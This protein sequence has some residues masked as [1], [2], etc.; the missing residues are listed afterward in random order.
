MSSNLDISKKNLQSFLQ[1]LHTNSLNY[2]C[3]VT[4]IS[5]ISFSITSNTFLI[6]N[7]AS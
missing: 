1:T 7:Q 4:S 5:L 6:D 2:C 3:I